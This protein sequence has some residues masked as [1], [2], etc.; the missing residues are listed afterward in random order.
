MGDSLRRVVK[1]AAIFLIGSVLGLFIAFIGRIIVIRYLTPAEFGLL[2]FSITVFTIACSL[3]NLGLPAGLTRQAAYFFGRGERE[4][5]IAIFRA[6]LLI[7]VVASL[8]AATG[9][10][11]SSDLIAEFFGMPG[12]SWILRMFSFAVPAAVLSAT[13]VSVFQ[14]Y[15]RVDVKVV[16]SDLL[17]NVLR[18]AL[19]VV[20]VILTL[21]FYW[22]VSVYVLSYIIPG[23][24][25]LAYTFRFVEFKT[26]E[27][28]SKYIRILVLF[29]LP[30][31]FQSVLGMIIT[32][33]DTLMIGYFLASSDVG[34]YSGARSLAGAM[35]NFLASVIFI[36]FPIISQLYARSQ[37]KEMGRTYAVITKW[38]MSTSL[39]VFLVLF[40]F[41][42]AVLW[43]LYGEA[44][45][46]AAHAL[47]ILA[48]GFFTH[49]MLGPNGMTLIAT[50]NVRFPTLASSIAAITNF[51][52][53]L[54][55]IPLY[56]ITGAAVASALTYTTG[57]ALT[58]AK[59]YM[60]YGIHP[61]TRNY[62]KPCLASLATAALVYLISKAF[63]LHIGSLALVLLFVAFLSIYFLS[64]LLT[65][66][67]DRE[68]IM[69]MLAIEERLGLD[70]SWVKRILRRFV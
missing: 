21:S 69:I 8:V 52:L 13:L 63:S 1:G 10:F 65:R 38:L 22:V 45:I 53:N 16:F 19:I 68:D 59:L 47:Q 3:A 50:G 55:L 42:E 36:Y 23:I 46:P 20:V 2:S 15:E 33:T 43:L 56:G 67:F 57:N 35:Q 60:D 6:G 48:L 7:S 58:S 34:L 25:L 64:L 37:I 14:V 66:S 31:L 39:P 40:F 24:V 18:V 62:V 12:V 11:V 27:N 61:F 9:L 49:V 29:S 54:V 26:S 30:L 28:T 17:P 51:A 44:Y 41:P 5:A 32:W 70:L 4:R